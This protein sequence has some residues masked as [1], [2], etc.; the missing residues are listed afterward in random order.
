MCCKFSRTST[1]PPHPTQEVTFYKNPKN[2]GAVF[3]PLA[4]TTTTTTTTT[5]YY[6]Y[7]YYYHY[8]DDD[9][10]ADY[11]YYYYFYSYYY[12]YSYSYSFLLLLLLL[13]LLLLV[14]GTGIGTDADE[15]QY[16]SVTCAGNVRIDAVKNL[17]AAPGSHTR[18]ILGKWF[19]SIAH[20]EHQHLAT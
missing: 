8:D 3:T 11:Y 18:I 15:A 10:D 12:S 2:A 4:T 6:Y 16:H 19:A 14:L 17:M 5:Y 7:Y 20:I 1:S 9:D 13:V